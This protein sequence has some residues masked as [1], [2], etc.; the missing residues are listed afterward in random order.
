MIL[1]CDPNLVVFNVWVNCLDPD[2]PKI[3]LFAARDIRKGE[4]LSFD[5]NSSCTRPV[6]QIDP[7]TDAE[8]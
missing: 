1:Q 4:E 5:Y 3:A 6:N 7:E 8:G 2:L